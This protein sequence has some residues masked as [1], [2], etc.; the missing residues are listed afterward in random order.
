VLSILI[1]EN[2]QPNG[3]IGHI[4]QSKPVSIVDIIFKYDKK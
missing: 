3:D 2:G 1:Q 4:L